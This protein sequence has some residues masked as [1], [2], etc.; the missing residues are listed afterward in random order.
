MR[1]AKA[2]SRA[3]IAL[4]FKATP[5]KERADLSGSFRSFRETGP[6]RRAL[7][8]TNAPN[9]KFLADTSIK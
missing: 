1:C 8:N 9:E 3:K 5:Q 4:A 6:L 2:L 7:V